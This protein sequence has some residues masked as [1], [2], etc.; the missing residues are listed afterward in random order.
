MYDIFSLLA[1]GTVPFATLAAYQLGLSHARRDTSR[2][3]KDLAVCKVECEK[4]DALLAEEQK[5]HECTL[6][7]YQTYVLTS[8]AQQD[9]LEAK[10]ASLEEILDQLHA[11]KNHDQIQSNKDF[12]QSVFDQ[13]AAEHDDDPFN[14][15]DDDDDE[16]DF[17]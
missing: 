8:M 12:W 2:L 13:L 6:K 3:V 16:V 4:R 10:F 11:E 7:D 1:V 5:S 14:D 17:S 9:Q 15:L